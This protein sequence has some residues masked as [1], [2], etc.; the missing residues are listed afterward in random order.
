MELMPCFSP[1][2]PPL[3]YCI[4]MFRVI[5]KSCEKVSVVPGLQCGCGVQ[6]IKVGTAV[7]WKEYTFYSFITLLFN[8]VQVLFI[9]YQEQLN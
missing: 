3:T 4:E 1:R 7:K 2:A 9:A 8:Y 5:S 6:S